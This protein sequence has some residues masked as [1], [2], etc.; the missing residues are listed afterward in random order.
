MI[1]VGKNM[2]RSI[3]FWGLAAK[4]LAQD[5]GSPNPRS[6]HFVP[7]RVGHALFGEGGW[8]P[9]MEDPGTLWLL[10]W[11]LLAPP[12]MLPVWWLA[13]ND[14]DVVEFEDSDLDQAIEAQIE[15]VSN[16]KT[17]HPSSRKKDVNALLRTYGPPARAYRSSIEDVLDCPLRE[18]KLIEVSSATGRYRFRL[19]PKSTLPSEVV[20][21]AV[22]DYIS[23]TE[24]GGNTVTIS[25][26]AYEPGAPG[27]VFKLSETE[28]QQMLEPVL[29]NSEALDHL[30]PTGASQVSWW[31]DPARIAV[32]VLNG[33]YKVA[34][35]NVRAGQYGDQS[36]D[37]DFLDS[38]DRKTH[39][40]PSFRST[41]SHPAT[42]LAVDD[43]SA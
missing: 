5:P 36:I 4:V 39:P 1:G 3:R 2:V 31:G 16:W 41:H 13:F 35:S 26:L 12:S 8:D 29:S 23:R 15:A 38:S 6:P 30:T 11:L 10:H 21:Y 24:T 28:L 20:A 32:E 9:F 42:T 34:Q 22:L 33:Y 27:R 18:L 40:R 14:F 37:D 25:R 43:G 17:P 7:T 19:G